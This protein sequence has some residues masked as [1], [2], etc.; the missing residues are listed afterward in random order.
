MKRSDIPTDILAPETVQVLRSHEWS[1]NV[2]ELANALEHATIMAGG[3]TLLPEHLPMTVGGSSGGPHL[4]LDINSF[5]APM[6]L[7]EIEQEVI[8][9]TLE[10][11]DGDKPK[12]ADE[13]GIA[14]KTL[15][16]KLHQYQSQSKAG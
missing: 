9:Q 5:T 6:S 2:R 10:K 11:Y 7:R 1:G 15:Y 13:L 3:Q 4:S 12:T 16:N 8:L 14:L